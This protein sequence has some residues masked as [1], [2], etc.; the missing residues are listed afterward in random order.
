[1]ARCFSQ[2]CKFM[3]A[4]AVFGLG[5]QVLGSQVPG[6]LSPGLAPVSPAL[7]GEVLAAQAGPASFRSAFTMGHGRK[8]GG[9]GITLA[10]G[11]H[12]AHDHARDRHRGWRGARRH[13]EVFHKGARGHFH[14][15]GHRRH[16]CHAQRAL[17]K[18][19]HLGVNRPAVRR[20]DDRRVVIAGYHR[21]YRVRVVFANRRGCPLIAWR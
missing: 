6:L 9:A 2:R 5:S 19:W 11:G 10:G 21:G 15:H 4:L 18:A 13:G 17:D 1:M 20:L 14:R 7:A 16:G 8:A 12:G 3:L